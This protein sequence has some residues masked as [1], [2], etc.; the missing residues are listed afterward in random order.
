MEGEEEVSVEGALVGVV[1]EGFDGGR[2][3]SGR[4]S[5]PDEDAQDFKS[6]GWDFYVLVK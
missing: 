2:K 1:R 5:L 3:A 4:F 6:C